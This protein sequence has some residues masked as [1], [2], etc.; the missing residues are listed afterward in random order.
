[1]MWRGSTQVRRT[2]VFQVTV[3]GRDYTLESK[4]ESDRVKRA[5]VAAARRRGGIVRFA[6]PDGRWIDMLVTPGVPLSFQEFDVPAAE[7]LS[8][9]ELAAQLAGV[10]FLDYLD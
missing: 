3:A 5:C 9:G 10:G 7:A 6:I 4:A 1:M 2:R 8:E